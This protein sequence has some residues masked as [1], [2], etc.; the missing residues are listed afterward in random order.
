[1]VSANPPDPARTYALVVGIETYEGAA[2]LNGPASD[3]GRFVDWLLRNTVYPSNIL[4]YMSPQDPNETAVAKL[5]AAVAKH[6]GVEDSSSWE[7]KPATEKNI[8]YAITEILPHWQGDLLILYWS[9]HGVISS[10]GDRECHRLLYSD[11]TQNSKSNANLESL[12]TALRTSTYAGL[13]RQIHIVDACAT[14]HP[15]HFPAGDFVGG[16]QVHDHE[17][18]VLLAAS[19]G[20]EARPLAEQ[21]TGLFSKTVFDWLK[22]HPAWPPDMEKLATY[23]SRRFDDLDDDG[24]AQQTPDRIQYKPWTGSA[25]I[26]RDRPCLAP[27]EPLTD[28]AALLDEVVAYLEDLAR[29]M[30]EPPAYY[31]AHLRGGD[32]RQTP[33]DAIRQVVQ[34]VEDRRALETWLAA[35]RERQRAAGEEG[36]RRAY[37]PRRSRPEEEPSEREERARPTPIVWDETAGARFHRAVVLGDPGC[38]K[39]WLLRCE[40]RRLALKALKTLREGDGPA[41]ARLE[42]VALPLFARLSDLNRS[43]DP[44]ANELVATVWGGQPRVTEEQAGPGRSSWEASLTAFRGWVLKRLELKANQCVVLLDAWDEVTDRRSTLERRLAEFARLYPS[45]RILL[46]SRIV[47]YGRTPVHGWQELELLAFE[48][49]EISAFVEAWFGVGTEAGR[50]F[51]ARIDGE[52]QVRGLARIPLMLALLCRTAG[53]AGGD[54]PARRVDLYDRCLWGLLRKWKEEDN[55]GENKDP[56]IS[57]AEAKAL[58]EALERVAEPLFAEGHEQFDERMLQ[59]RLDPWLDALKPSHQLHGRKAASVIADLKRDGVLVTANADSHA[60]LLFLHRTF[61]EYLVASALGR[62]ANDDCWQAIAATVDRR[63]WLPNWEEVI[64]L[65][66]GLLEDPEPLLTMLAKADATSSNPLGDDYFRHRL[67]LVA[68]CLPSLKPETRTT[69]AP[70]VDAITTS[71]V[72]RWWEAEEHDTAKTVEHLTRALPALAYVNGRITRRSDVPPKPL[73]TWLA[74]GL[75]DRGGVSRVLTVAPDAATLEAAMLWALG[76]AAATPE[77]VTGLVARLAD[78]E[79]IVRDAAAAALGALGAAAATPEALTGLVARL[80]DRDRWVQWKAAAALGAQMVQGV[81]VFR[82]WTWWPWPRRKWVVDTVEQ[83]ALP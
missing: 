63:A 43:D 35:E 78:P 34:V 5:R 40:A 62:R 22:K 61:H 83:L 47:G 57:N 1:M 77:V 38:G 49:P 23:V 8:R 17:Q 56:A 42:A 53:A 69:V 58:I 70:T 51:L 10:D 79:A 66:A 11:T 68:R 7:V 2:A 50:R 12:L 81:R 80:A 15:G 3:A 41:A 4:V 32:A 27:G 45:P 65:L 13:R 30:A 31:P 6:C 54:V 25:R 16:K 33:F 64:V 55:K 71:C 48:R 52:P 67:A 82:R 37:D 28:T 18:V 20:E 74:R 46:A 29:R 72:K 24:K 39:S 36:E 75:A 26:L 14:L 21:Q 19:R 73:L 76:T 59:E 9:G 60:E 44:F